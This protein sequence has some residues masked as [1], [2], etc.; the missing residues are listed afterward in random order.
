MLADIMLK[1]GVLL[2]GLRVVYSE[3]FIK[4]VIGDTP[5]TCDRLDTKTFIAS[6]LE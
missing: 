5:A 1:A 3:F 6:M 2:Q 4:F